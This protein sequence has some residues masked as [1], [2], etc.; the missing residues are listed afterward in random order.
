MIE[1]SPKNLRFFLTSKETEIASIIRKNY[2]HTPEQI[3]KILVETINCNSL[4]I[5]PVLRKEVKEKSS[6]STP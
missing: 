6:K 2:K 1:L 4:A 5:F 3:A